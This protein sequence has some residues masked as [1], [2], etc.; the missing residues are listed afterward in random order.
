L[1]ESFACHA[2]WLTG[3]SSAD[4]IDRP[5]G[6]PIDFFNIAIDRDRRTFR[7][8]KRLAPRINFNLP[9]DAHPGSFKSKVKP[10]YAAEKTT[11]R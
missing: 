1:G 6:F 4:K 3:E 10:S 11:D 9:F 2:D 7:H 5:N 8:E